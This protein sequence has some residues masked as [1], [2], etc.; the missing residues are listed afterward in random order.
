MKLVASFLALV[1]ASVSFAGSS[2]YDIP[3]VDIDGNETT[4]ASHKGKVMLI[5]NVASNCGFTSQYEGLQRLNA[6]KGKDG[7]VVLGFPSNQFGGQEPG[8]N[9]QIKEFCATHY[10]VSFPM[11]A[12]IDVNGPE[13]HPLYAHLTGKDSPFPGKIGWNFSKFVVNREGEITA[14]FSSFVSPNSNK[15]RSAIDN[16]LAGM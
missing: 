16:A 1:F 12:K 13:Q 4:L 3:V 9:E 10:S 5:V 7:L 14:R 6:E 2:I 15:L 11:F 8:S